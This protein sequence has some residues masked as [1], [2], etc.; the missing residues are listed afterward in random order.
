[1]SL[2]I[3]VALSLL[4]LGRSLVLQIITQVKNTLLYLLVHA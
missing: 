3:T 1:M 4:R 2:V